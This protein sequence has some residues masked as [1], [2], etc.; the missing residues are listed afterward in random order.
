M[1]RDDVLIPD[2]EFT[3][4]IYSCRNLPHFPCEFLKVFLGGGENALSII[5]GHFPSEQY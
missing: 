5:T 1:T 2:W 3:S 4:R